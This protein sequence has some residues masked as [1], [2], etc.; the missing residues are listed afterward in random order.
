[1]DSS[2]NLLAEHRRMMALRGVIPPRSK[3]SPPTHRDLDRTIPFCHG[4]H[5][6]DQLNQNG[7]GPGVDYNAIVTGS[8]GGV[9]RNRD[10]P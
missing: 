9:A 2:D 10:L 1:M 5:S 7:V 4:L 8:A 6:R 3:P